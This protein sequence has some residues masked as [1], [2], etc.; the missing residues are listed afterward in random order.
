MTQHRV[1]IIGAGVA[2]LTVARE[3][4]QREIAVDLIERAPFAGGHG[5]QLACKATDRCV[6]CGACM[7]EERLQYAG[8]SPHIRLMTLSRVT[9]ISRNGGV[10][11]RVAQNPICI[12]P[13]RCT[14]CGQ[15]L[16][17][18]P[19]KGAL[20]Q[21]TSAYH[22][23]YYAV[24]PENCLYFKDE[25]CRK[26]AEVCPEGAVDLNSAAGEELAVTAD[27]LVVATGFTPFDPTTKPYGYGRFPNV[28]T[29]LDLDRTLRVTG[30]VTRPGEGGAVNRIAFIQCVGS[31][32]AQC[33]HLWCSQ[34][35]CGA[36]LR[37]ARWI[38]HR[39][40]ETEVTCFYI[41]IQT[42]GGQFQQQYRQIQEEIRLVRMIPA[43]IFEAEAGQV[44]LGYQDPVSKEARD[45]LFDLVVLAVGLT[46]GTGTA[47]V[48]GMLQMGDEWARFPRENDAHP[49]TLPAGVFMV[50]TAR[51]PMGIAASVADGNAT[52]ADV[53]AYL[54]QDA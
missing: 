51:G 46:P 9:E 29:T 50:G 52:A 16:Q 36:S 49:G 17:V 8:Q 12:D 26:C 39:R 33:G 14:D 20:V 11:A 27:A 45:E 31:R 40:P 6:S 23:P 25:S 42:F 38:K 47:D 13:K 43:D 41:D 2:G 22:Q 24:N 35:C 18:C 5:A 54:E 30:K 3:L 28:V 53:A 32:D 7:V 19:H 37:M 34:I 1:L 44:R 15:C 48:M 21:G 10:R 4:A